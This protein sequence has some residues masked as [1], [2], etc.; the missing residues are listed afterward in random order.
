MNLWAPE[1]VNLKEKLFLTKDFQKGK[2]WKSSAKKIWN[3]RKIL[4]PLLAESI[5]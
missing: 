4:K 1:G 2:A 5:N 3:G